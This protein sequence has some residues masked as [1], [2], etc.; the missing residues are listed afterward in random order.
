MR[1]IVLQYDHRFDD[2]LADLDAAVRADPDDAQAWAW[3]TAIHLVRVDL[4]K[5]HA[6]LRAAGRAHARSG[7]RARARRRSMR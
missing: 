2:A 6:A 4:D 5:A 7:G 1:A 3:I